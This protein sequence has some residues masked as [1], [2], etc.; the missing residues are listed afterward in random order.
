MTLNVGLV[1]GFAIL[2]LTAAAVIVSFRRNKKAIDALDESD[3]RTLKI[4]VP[5]HR[6]KWTQK[7]LHS[8]GWA[9]DEG[10]N[11]AEGKSATRL[12]FEKG[13]AEGASSLKEVLHSLNRSM[14]LPASPPDFSP[15]IEDK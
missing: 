9:N 15:K 6:I 2:L 10:R 13:E 12:T 8:L 5:N 1:I 3:C 14:A 11:C 4:S 7:K